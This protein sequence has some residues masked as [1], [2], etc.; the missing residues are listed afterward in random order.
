MPVCFLA[1]DRKSVGQDGS[2]SG[3]G[4]GGVG[5]RENLNQNTLYGKMYSQ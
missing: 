4:L 5:G 2:G 1:R 3:G